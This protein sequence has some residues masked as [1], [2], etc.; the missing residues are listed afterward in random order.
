MHPRV[1]TLPLLVL[2]AAALVLA[3]APPAMAACHSFTVVVNPS[4]VTE[5]GS[6]TVTV[7]RDGAL[8]P[9]SV[10]VASIN[11]TATGGND[12]TSVHQTVAFTDE[13]EKTFTVSTIEDAAHEQTETFRLHLGNGSGC[14]PTSE[15]S[16]GPDARVTIRDDDA[17]TTSPTPSATPSETPT[18]SPTPRASVTRSPTPTPSV[19]VVSPT[20]EETPSDTPTLPEGTSTAL[21][22]GPGDDG[23]FSPGR[24]TLMVIGSVLLAGAAAGLLALY[25]GRP[26]L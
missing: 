6:V 14:L 3:S 11:E 22:A 12:Y 5:G 18:R 7:T 19:V 2:V 17:A 1:R 15:F 8:A 26:Q 16:Y 21:A 4:T 10:D 20:P 9:S 25:R 23:P 24:V 13:T